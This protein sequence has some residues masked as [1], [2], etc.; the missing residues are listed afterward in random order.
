MCKKSLL[1]TRAFTNLISFMLFYSPCR[2]VGLEDIIVKIWFYNQLAEFGNGVLII[3]KPKIPKSIK[4]GH[5]N[6]CTELEAIIALGGT[7]G[8]K[9]KFLEDV[10]SKHFKKEEEYAL[11]PLGFLLALSEGSWEIDSDAAIKMADRLQ[12]KLSELKEEHVQI[13]KAFRSLK[14]VA[15]EEGEISAKQFVKDLT[16]HVEIEDQVLYPTTIL[17]GNYLKNLRLH[18]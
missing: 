4:N 12:A 11:P 18:H 9:A 15:D 3:M 2:G 6:L 10:M 5:E 14:I 17:I 7:I 16:L 8:E 13:A 1:V